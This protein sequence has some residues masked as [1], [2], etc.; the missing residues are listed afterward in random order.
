MEGGDVGGADTGH[1]DAEALLQVA[2]RD[3]GL[4]GDLATEFMDGGF[5]RRGERRAL[6]L[7]QGLAGNEQREQF[8]FG[9]TQQWKL[10]DRL[11]IIIPVAGGVVFDG[12]AQAVAHEID[13]AANGFNRRLD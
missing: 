1:T 5:Q 3:V 4:C 12:E 10:L 9:N 11:A 7:R 8:A 6:E 2:K 13:V